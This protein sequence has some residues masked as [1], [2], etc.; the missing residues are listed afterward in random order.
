VNHCSDCRHFVD[1]EVMGQCRAHPQFVH[2]HRND[3]CGELSPKP[4]PNTTLTVS[5]GSAVILPVVDAMTEPKKRK[6]T[7]RQDA[8][9]SA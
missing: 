6:Y 7:R 2:K 3:W 4:L 8:K 5:A 9:T 1:H